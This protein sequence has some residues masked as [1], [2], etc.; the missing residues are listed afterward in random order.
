[1][2]INKKIEE[3]RK[4]PE[5]VRVRYVFGAV[6]VVMFFIII[7]WLFSLQDTFRDS[8]E[9]TE[10]INPPSIGEELNKTREELPSLR[11][12]VEESQQNLEDLE[13]NEIQPPVEEG[14][15]NNE[16]VEN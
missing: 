5:H 3:V 2:D 13:K 14:T 12:F 9:Q 1:M 4:Q 6:A 16:S 7:I 11:E 10:A 8:R 15:A